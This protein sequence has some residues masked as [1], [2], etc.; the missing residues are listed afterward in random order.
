MNIF[1]ARLNYD[2]QEG[3]LRYAFEEFGEVDSAK[4]ITDHY[5]GQSKGYGFV[6]MPN[7]NE[8]REAIN[9][10]NDDYLDG[11]TIVVKK[12]KPRGSSRSNS[13]NSTYSGSSY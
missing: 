9:V 8:A 6:E 3:D 5:T 4:I 12:A 1:V 10:L 11:R 2:T 13:Y 7:D